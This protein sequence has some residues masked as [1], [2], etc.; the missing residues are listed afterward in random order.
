MFVAVLAF[1]FDQASVADG[2]IGVVRRGGKAYLLGDEGRVRQ[3]K[4]TASQYSRLAH[5]GVQ[6]RLLRGRA[7]LE[8]YHRASSTGPLAS[9]HGDLHAKV[10]LTPTELLVGSTNF[11][12]AFQSNIEAAA[13]IRRSASGA[14]EMR[15]WFQRHWDSDLEH[16]VSGRSA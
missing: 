15:A 8:A 9:R 3:S 10:L 12:T 6:V 13:H 5:N 7:L 11:T 1:T 4:T 14:E 2:L 16:Y